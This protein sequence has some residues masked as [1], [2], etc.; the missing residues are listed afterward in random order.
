VAGDRDWAQGYLEQA[1][2]DLAGA[3]AMGS[4]SPSTVAMLWQMVFEKS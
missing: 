3:R 2:A 4:A 1:P